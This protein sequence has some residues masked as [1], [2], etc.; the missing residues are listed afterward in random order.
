M[1][2]IMMPVI[3]ASELESAVNIQ[4]GVNIEDITSLLFGDCFINDSYK[5]FYYRENETYNGFPWENE[6]DIRH[7]NLVRA[8]L[9]DTIPDYDRV[10]IYVSW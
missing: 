9:Q 5:S 8:Y 7:R 2:V 1:K 4:F 3:G 6:E 10:L